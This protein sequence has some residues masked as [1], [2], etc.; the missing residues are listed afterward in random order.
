MNI[1]KLT[2]S[3]A[4]VV[5]SALPQVTH[6]S[7]LGDSVSC[8]TSPAPGQPPLVCDPSSATVGSGVEFILSE[9]SSLTFELLKID[10]GASSIIF[11]P[12]ARTDFFFGDKVTFTSLDDALNPARVI[13]AVS[14]SGISD[15]TEL[16]NADLTFTDH[17]LTID[18]NSVSF[19]NANSTA[20][21]DLTFRDTTTKV[22]EPASIALLG[23]AMVGL[24]FAR[25]KPK[26]S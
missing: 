16:T 13:A 2:I 5:L 4:T 24:G 26:Q 12:F 14:L 9:V 18:F 3:L 6:A 19:L 20:T 17:S 23:I 21:I 22:P 25:R 15:V 1:T 10:F 8:T 7:L 11:T